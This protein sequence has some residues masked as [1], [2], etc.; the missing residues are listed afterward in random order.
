MKI[1]TN[2]LLTPAQIRKYNLVICKSEY[3][4]YQNDFVE[5]AKSAW[6]FECSIACASKNQA[7][8]LKKLSIKNSSRFPFH[9]QSAQHFLYKAEQAATAGTSIY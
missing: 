5:N 8:K 3:S 6:F 7:K 2:L 9:S 4:Q 1:E